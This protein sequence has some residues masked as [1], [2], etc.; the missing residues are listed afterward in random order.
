MEKDDYFVV[1]YKILAYL[2]ITLKEGSHPDALLLQHDSRLLGVNEM[3]WT[4][5]MEN[6]QEQGYLTGLTVIT[7]WDGNKMI[8]GLECCQITPAGIAYLLDDYMLDKAKTSLLEKN[9]SI[10]NI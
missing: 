8:F 2:Y 1:V 9:I 6:L 7:P 3:Y 5:I 10:P 4:Y